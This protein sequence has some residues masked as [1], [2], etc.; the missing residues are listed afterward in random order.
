M[1]V[2]I[3]GVTKQYE[4]GTGS[5]VSALHDISLSIGDA[6]FV[7]I[8]G[9]SGCGKST[10][11]KLIAGLEQ[12]S[13]GQIAFDND[14]WRGAATERGFIFQDYALFPWLTVRDNIRFG[15]QMQRVPRKRQR[16]IVDEYLQSFGLVDAAH[17]YPKQL[18]GGMSQRVAIARAFC[19]KPKLLLMDEPFAA[20]DAILRQKLQEEVDR[21]WAKEKITFIL[22]THDVEEAIY[23]ADRIIVMTHG[24]GRIKHSVNI[25][26]PR[27]RIRTESDFVELR[28]RLMRLL[29]DEE[30]A[31]HSVA[32]NARL[33]PHTEPS[34]ILSNVQ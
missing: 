23:L 10:L 12:P 19:L 11:L 22:V 2:D 8:L 29:H 33:H 15:L 24:P 30:D 13:Q 17:L 26:I 25:D 34:V 4:T 18:S 32:M 7:C 16:E 31:I 14:K 27:P 3:S 5:Q 6:E 9:P 28:S 20:L 1:H 21:I